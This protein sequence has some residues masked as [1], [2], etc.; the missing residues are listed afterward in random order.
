MQ[1]VRW[2][3]SRH[4]HPLDC[5]CRTHPISLPVALVPAPP[6]T[7]FAASENYAAVQLPDGPATT[8]FPVYD[9]PL[10]YGISH[11]SVADDQPYATAGAVEYSV[12]AARAAMMSPYEYTY[13]DEA[14]RH[15]ALGRPGVA[16]AQSTVS[17]GEPADS[18]SRGIP[19]DGKL[20]AT[21]SLSLSSGHAAAR[22]DYLSYTPLLPRALWFPPSP[23]AVVCLLFT[24][25]QLRYGIPP[26]GE[27]VL[28]VSPQPTGNVF[29]VHGPLYPAAVGTTVCVPVAASSPRPG[30]AHT[31]PVN[32]RHPARFRFDPMQARRRQPGGWQTGH[33]LP[34]AGRHLHHPPR[35]TQP[36]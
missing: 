22:T 9:T 8:P 18:M 13:G 10:T 16:G 6:S 27:Q 29:N 26:S 7:F 17:Y 14:F 12:E 20:G 15:S 25:G 23:R 28:L 19:G 24:E 32:T 33:R 11:L 30:C 31:S 3:F 1:Q 36:V 4:R 35:Q 5:P 2:S 21:P 34:R